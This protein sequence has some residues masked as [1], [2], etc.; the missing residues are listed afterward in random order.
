MPPADSASRAGVTPKASGDRSSRT[1]DKQI[2]PRG[3]N[4]THSTTSEG[5]SGSLRLFVAELCILHF[6]G[7]HR[8]RTNQRHNHFGRLSWSVFPLNHCLAVGSMD[9][10]AFRRV[11]A[12]CWHSCNSIALAAAFYWISHPFFDHHFSGILLVAWFGRFKEVF[13]ATRNIKKCLTSRLT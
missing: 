10:R 1:L 7:R 4:V 2:I 8:S 12:G 11:S 6:H 9:V 5:Y 13:Y 3:N